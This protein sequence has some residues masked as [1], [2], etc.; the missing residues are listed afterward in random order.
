M[1]TPLD[2]FA[3]KD[4]EPKWV[5]CA[6]TLAR[7]LLLAIRQGEGWYFVFSQQTGDRDFYRV[8][9]DGLVERAAS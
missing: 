9:A 7:V 6:E 5:G 2:L 4:G 8:R 1:G 3:V